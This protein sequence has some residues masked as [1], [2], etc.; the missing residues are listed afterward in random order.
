MDEVEA[1]QARETVR[2]EAR[3]LRLLFVL[4][5][6]GLWA[7]Y[8]VSRWAIDEEPLA[9]TAVTGLVFIAFLGAM[10]W[11]FAVPR[12]VRRRQ[13]ALQPARVGAITDHHLL[14]ES[15]GRPAVLV[16]HQAGVVHVLQ[17]DRLRARPFLDLR[18]RVLSPGERWLELGLAGF[19]L[20]P[21]HATSGVVYTMTT[22]PSEGAG[23]PGGPAQWST[24]TRW[25]AD[26]DR[27]EVD[28]GSATVLHR[29]PGPVLDHVGGAVVLDEQGR[30]FTSLGVPSGSA[31]AQDPTS[32]AGALWCLADPA[33]VDPATTGLA[34]TR[35]SWGYRNP[36]R[37]AVLPGHGVLVGEALWT[38]KH[39]SLHLPRRGDNA[40]YPH[41]GT[42]W[43]GRRRTPDS[44]QTPLG[45]PV[46][47][48]VLE[49]GP[50]VGR[51]LSGVVPVAA[52]APGPWAGGILV[53]D[54][55]GAVLLAHPGP[56]PW[57]WE[58]VVEPGVLVRQDQLLWDLAPGPEGGF[59]ALVTTS[60]MRDGVILQVSAG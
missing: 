46:A 53:A 34:P 16:P 50:E 26:P 14:L 41:V 58:Q 4:M 18:D 47:A 10:G 56:P 43:D 24:L 49:Y 1:D 25:V 13:V 3:R 12:F 33:T 19:A 11:A 48:P 2:R 54:W 20:A 7:G 5:L 52:D 44:R 30:L 45:D 57:R 21:D 38:D 27:C 40:G 22:E 17:G 51:I 6:V 29:A 37:L 55:R 15:T 60:A 42:C 31:L 35:W 23:Q 32:W 8:A 59:H 39:Q 36:W 9:R 28:P